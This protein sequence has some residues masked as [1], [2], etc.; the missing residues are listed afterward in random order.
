VEGSLDLDA[1]M[2]REVRLTKAGIDETFRAMLAVEVIGTV[3]RIDEE[4]A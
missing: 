3:I 2:S 4:E 1:L